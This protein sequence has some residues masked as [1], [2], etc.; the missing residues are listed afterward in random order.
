MGKKIIHQA[1]ILLILVLPYLYAVI[2]NGAIG[3]G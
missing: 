2:D 1:F 3:G